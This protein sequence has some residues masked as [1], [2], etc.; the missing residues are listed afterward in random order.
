MFAFGVAYLSL[1]FFGGSNL[2]AYRK[3]LSNLDA[4]R[5]VKIGSQEECNASFDSIL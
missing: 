2:G 5:K 4:Y 3:V 1:D